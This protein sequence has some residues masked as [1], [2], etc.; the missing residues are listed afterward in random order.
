MVEGGGV[1]VF[2]EVGGGGDEFVAA[3]AHLEEGDDFATGSVEDEGVVG[4][5]AGGA[6]LFVLGGGEGRDESGDL[7]GAEFDAFGVHDTTVHAAVDEEGTFFLSGVVVT[8][9]ADLGEGF[10]GPFDNGARGWRGRCTD[11][12]V[13]DGAASGDE[14]GEGNRG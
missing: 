11:S 10:A 6:G 7:G 3:E 14:G 9:G 13:G 12:E 8:I 5:V 1:H 4:F 2:G